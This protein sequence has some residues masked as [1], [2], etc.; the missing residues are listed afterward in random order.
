M[1]FYLTKHTCILVFVKYQHTILHVILSR[2]ARQ[3][4]RLQVGAMGRDTN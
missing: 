1:R 4:C 2:L 3:Q